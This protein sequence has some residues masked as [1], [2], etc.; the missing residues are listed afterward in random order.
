MAKI[1]YSLAGEG[2]G[3]ATRVRAVIQDLEQEHEITVFAPGD[4]YQLLQPAHRNT[5]VTLHHLPGLGFAYGR[6]RQLDY[7]KTGLQS[8]NYLVNAPKLITKLQAMKITE[9]TGVRYK[10]TVA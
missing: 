1:F 10:L 3:H 6:N 9:I 4:A 2:R 5:A 7:V 8:L